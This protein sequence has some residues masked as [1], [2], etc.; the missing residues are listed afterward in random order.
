MGAI[1]GEGVKKQL[2]RPRLDPLTVLVREAAQNSWDA[3]APSRVGPVRFGIHLRE[4]SPAVAASWRTT[5]LDGAPTPERLPLMPILERPEL[6]V[7][8]VSDRGTTGLGGPTRA[9]RAVG[10]EPHDY[11]S[12]FLNVGDPRDTQFGGGTYGYGKAVFFRNSEASTAVVYTRCTNEDGED[13]SRL[14]GCALDRGY[15]AEGR[16]Y[17]GR[18]WFGVPVGDGVA[19]PVRGAAAD[20]LARELGFPDFDEGEHG[21]TIAVLAPRLGNR[22]GEQAMRVAADS[23]LWHLW[24]KMVARG[25]NAAAMSFEVTCEGAPVAIP[26]PDEHPALREFAKALDDLDGSGGTIAFGP[27]A[28]PIGKILLRTTFAPPPVID[29]VGDAAGLATGIHHCCLLRVPELVVEYRPGPPMPDERIWYAGVFRVLPDHD[30]TFASAE[31]PTH[32]SWSADDLDGPERSIV[33]TTLRKIDE[34]L[35]SHASPLTSEDD[36]RGVSDGL[37]ALSRFLGS[38]LAPAPGDAAD[39]QSGDGPGKGGRSKVRMVGT[40]RWAEHDGRDVLIQEFEVDD[41][42]AVTVEAETSVRVWGGG[43]KET[44][45]PRGAGQPTLVG[46]RAPDGTVHPSGRLAIARGEGGNWQA[47]VTAPPD[48]ATRVRVHEARTRAGDG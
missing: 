28:E 2:G 8:F 14:V 46:W 21:S 29:E 47:I 12:F 9:D 19:D 25:G 30:E 43:G 48:T 4:L 17:T 7:L 22:D 3:A 5:L 26:E 36:A 31:P 38:L 11:V 44:A 33:R 34:K 16:A 23:V 40:P 18:H 13:E 27:G 24:P 35:R 6:S 41:S 37:A 42:R 15:E 45:P 10:G 39:P 1:R 20:Q 32:D